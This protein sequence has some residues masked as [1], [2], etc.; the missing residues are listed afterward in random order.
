MKVD[1]LP[2]NPHVPTLAKTRAHATM[3][4]TTGILASTPLGAVL[5]IFI[6]DTG[7]SD[8]VLLCDRTMRMTGDRPPTSALVL[9]AQVARQW[10]RLSGHRLRGEGPELGRR[11]CRP[12]L[13]LQKMF[14]AEGV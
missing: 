10:K 7:L 11:S 8:A 9:R 12:I 3:Q 14:C 6:D 1:I 4:A 2:Q 5:G 13:R